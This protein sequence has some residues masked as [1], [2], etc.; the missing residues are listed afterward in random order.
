MDCVKRE[1]ALENTSP[2]IV[3][4]LRG[5][6]GLRPTEEPPVLISYM[7]SKEKNMSPKII[8]L[9][10]EALIEARDELKSAVGEDAKRHTALCVENLENAY[11]RAALRYR[12]NGLSLP[13]EDI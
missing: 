7:A 3:A 10:R 2:E 12:L 6:K 5:N 8:G 13:G 4:R 11:V 9:I 1:Y